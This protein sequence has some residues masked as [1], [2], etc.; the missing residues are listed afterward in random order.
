M[1]YKLSPLF[2]HILIILLSFSST[3]FAN[4]ET[5]DK[6]H[7]D[8]NKIMT[9]KV[10]NSVPV[11]ENAYVFAQFTDKM[12]MVVNYFTLSTEEQI[13]DFYQKSY[14]EILTRELKR[15]RLTLSYHHN[16]QKIRVVISQ[17]NKKR[18]VD[19]II[20]NKE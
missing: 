12:P 15:D 20:Q 16:E 19:I 4:D 9:E 1:N 8:D 11:I 17:Q 7:I 13:I 6:D 18:Q 14:G 3:T 2:I 10:L 5:T